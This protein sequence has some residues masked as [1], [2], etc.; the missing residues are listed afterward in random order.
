MSAPIDDREVAF[1]SVG[2]GGIGSKQSIDAHGLELAFGVRDPISKGSGVRREE[3]GD[4]PIAPSVRVPDWTTERLDPI[5]GTAALLAVE[6][7]DHPCPESNARVA[8]S[9]PSIPPTFS[10]GSSASP[11]QAP[12]RALDG[13]LLGDHPFLVGTVLRVAVPI[14]ASDSGFPLPA[15][16]RQKAGPRTCSSAKTSSPTCERLP[17]RRL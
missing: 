15:R 8:S 9:T 10:I 11:S 16:S 3:G 5:A 1:R 2:I 13:E 4:D 17:S 12:A 14:V 6:A 7:V